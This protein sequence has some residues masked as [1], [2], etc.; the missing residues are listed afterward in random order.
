[1][2]L[3]T[4]YVWAATG[5][6]ENMVN[7]EYYGPVGIPGRHLR[8]SRDVGLAEELWEWTQKELEGFTS[9]MFSLFR[10]SW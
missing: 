3:G 4:S 9:N 7:R 10:V 1:M 8:K 2:V 6:K 5:N